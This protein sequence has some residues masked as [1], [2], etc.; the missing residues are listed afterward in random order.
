[1][2]Q[3]YRHEVLLAVQVRVLLLAGVPGGGVEERPQGHM[4]A[5]PADAEDRQIVTHNISKINSTPTS[6][7]EVT[8]GH[9]QKQIW[10]MQSTFKINSYNQKKQLLYS[11]LLR[12]AYI[13]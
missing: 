10:R 8:K 4:Q 3:N 6:A 7:T 12:P 9:M 13:I 11:P 5:D 1:M 2:W